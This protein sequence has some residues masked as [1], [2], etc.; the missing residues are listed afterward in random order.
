MSFVLGVVCLMA[1]SALL[2]VGSH[3]TNATTPWGVWQQITDAV[4]T[5]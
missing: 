2:W 5:T 1:G 3:S 4:G